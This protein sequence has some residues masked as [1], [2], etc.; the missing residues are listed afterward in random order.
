MYLKSK[1]HKIESMMKQKENVAR[2]T[3]DKVEMG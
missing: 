2:W 1:L 3:I